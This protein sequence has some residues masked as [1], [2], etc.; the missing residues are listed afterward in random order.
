MTIKVLVT[1][2]AGKMGRAMSSGIITADDMSVVGAVDMQCIGYDLGDLC[3]VGPIGV[4]VVDDLSAAIK[5]CGADV[6]LDFSGPTAVMKNVRTALSAGLP[7]V[8]GSTGLT[9]NDLEELAGLAAANHAAVFVAP[10]FALSAV[11]MMRF[12]AE[13]VKY[14][15]SYE[16]IE[17]HHEHKLDAPSGTAL[18]TARMMSEHREVMTQGELDSFEVLPGARGGDYQ[19]ARIHSV[20]LPGFVASQEVIFGGVG[21]T[22]TIRQDSPGR[23]CFWPGVELA[24]RKISS[25]HGLVVGLDKLM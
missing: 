12:A 17:L 22:L 3:A 4:P 11:L 25:L 24:L 2:A 15:P 19:G 1:G 10:N 16:I 5:S 6:M 7:C 18:A 20:R 9:D 21:Q 8:V 13:A 14:F 23:D